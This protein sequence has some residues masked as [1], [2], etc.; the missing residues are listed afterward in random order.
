M[1]PDFGSCECTSDCRS[2]LLSK[3][4]PAFASEYRYLHGVA[5]VALWARIRIPL[6][7]FNVFIGG[8]ICM[9]FFIVFLFF[10]RFWRSTRDPLFLYFS[11][12]FFVLM[13]ERLVRDLMP[14]HTEWTPFVYSLRLIAFVLIL[15]GIIDK[16]RRP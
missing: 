12:A 10:V 4:R 13:L 2:D 5:G 8:A 9:G 3:R 1:F 14:I 15:I 7:M 11:S 16:N 6:T